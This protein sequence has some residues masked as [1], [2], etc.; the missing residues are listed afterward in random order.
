MLSGNNVSIKCLGK[1]GV[2]MIIIK[3][4]NGVDYGVLSIPER[5][6]TGAFPTIWFEA[7]TEEEA[8]SKADKTAKQ[9]GWL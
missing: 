7:D 8:M 6:T 4:E 5:G 3:Y 1:Y 9:K 2:A